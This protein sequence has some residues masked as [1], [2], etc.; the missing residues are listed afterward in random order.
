MCANKFL[1]LSIA[2]LEPTCFSMLSHNLFSN[3]ALHPKIVGFTLAR[4]YTFT[5]FVFAASG[6]WAPTFQSYLLWVL[7]LVVYGLLVDRIF[8]TDEVFEVWLL[9]CEV[10]LYGFN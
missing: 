6:F 8:N 5:G 3:S 2:Q 9:L 4:L 1:I 7:V 10:C